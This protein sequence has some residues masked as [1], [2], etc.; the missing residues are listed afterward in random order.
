M[1]PPESPNRILLYL[2]FLK[3]QSAKCTPSL[4]SLSSLNWTPCQRDGGTPAR[5]RF[6]SPCW[7]PRPGTSEKAQTHF[8]HLGNGHP[9]AACLEL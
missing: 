9:S 8:T 4:P 7:F 1:M 2:E 6:C 3:L 5:G